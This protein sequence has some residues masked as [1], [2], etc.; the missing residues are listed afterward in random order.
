MWIDFDGNFINLE[1]VQC[2]I[3]C[4]DKHSNMAPF[5]LAAY[6]DEDYYFREIF[7]TKKEMEKRALEIK[8]L[9]GI[10][11]LGVDCDRGVVGLY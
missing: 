3:K 2:F 6:F 8:E 4:E 11:M 7:S 9:L 5:Y 1:K 10:H